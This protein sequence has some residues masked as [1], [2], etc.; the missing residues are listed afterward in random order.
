M[1]QN[2]KHFRFCSELQSCLSQCV[3]ICCSSVLS[4]V[5][6]HLV[7]QLRKPKPLQLPLT[8]LNPSQTALIKGRVNSQIKLAAHLS[9]GLAVP[10][11]RGSC[12]WL[13]PMCILINN[14]LQKLEELSL[15]GLCLQYPLQEW[16]TDI[17]WEKLN[18]PCVINGS[19]VM[20]YHWCTDSLL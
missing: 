9:V 12:Q 6:S 15:D 19:A 7:T 5:L 11:S 13:H 14:K 2:K 16:Q 20:C 4:H 1:K 10:R 18:I 3:D 17:V 8:P